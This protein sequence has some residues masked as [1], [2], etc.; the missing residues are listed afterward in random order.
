MAR[1]RQSPK[2]I[3]KPTDTDEA[4]DGAT[5]LGP[6]SGPQTA[7]LQSPADIVIYGGSAGSGKSFGLLLEPLRS[8]VRVPRATAAIFRR[9]TVNIKRPGGLWDESLEIYSKIEG[10]VPTAAP[11]KWDFTACGGGTLVMGHLEYEATVYDWHGAQIQVLLFDELT[12]F[13][14]KQFWYMLT[15]N[16]SMTG[17][18][19][20]VRATCNP[21]A[22][23][24][25]AELIAW[26]IDQETGFPIPERAGVLRWFIRL[27]DKII[28]ADDPSELTHERLQVPRFNER[29]TEQ[30][31]MPMSLT[32]IPALID[33]N[34]A[35]MKKDPSYLAKLLAQ[36]TVE[37]E[38][39]L[40]G[41][42]KIRPAAGL[43]FQRHWVTMVGPNH[44]MKTVPAQLIVKRGW[45]LAATEKTQTNDPDW[46]AGTKIGK[47]LDGR[48]F[49]LDHVR[50]RGNPG[51]V[52]RLIKGTAATDG[53]GVEQHLPQDPGQAGKAQ[54]AY[55]AK[56]LDGYTVR[57]SL[58]TGDKETR[59]GPFSAQAEAGNVYVVEGPWNDEFFRVLEGF[60][61]GKHDD[62]VDSTARAFNAFQSGTT[63]IIEYFQQQ[64]H[65]VE[66]E[67]LKAKAPPPKT[68]AEG[69]IAVTGPP[70][71]NLL[72]DVKGRMIIADEHGVFVVEPKH[73]E[74]LRGQKG[75]KAVESEGVG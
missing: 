44:P 49:V 18:P 25:V 54:R 41:N 2:Q 24:W 27:G 33:D 1:A 5:I 43:Y 16:R 29:G 47:S 50:L 53:V 17:I 68:V 69:G 4:L 30:P 19:P 42:W 70:G 9:T 12:E 46:T 51:E 45:D 74:H 35:L 64:A 32:F 67:K 48:Y 23:S 57:F 52:D 55:M 3:A 59:F 71:V 75:W 15:R 37:R 31:L 61:D 56:T 40:N 66:L 28:W 14:Q 7:F 63:G 22:D 73:W 38:R 26:W 58:E 34:P 60:P 11:P 20:Y 21:D 6:Q 72:Y 62:D 39:L 65:K 10:A 36:P 8:V 13:T